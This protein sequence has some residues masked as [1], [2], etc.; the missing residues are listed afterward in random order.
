ML[1]LSESRNATCI[2]FA[3]TFFF[4]SIICLFLGLVGALSGGTFEING[5]SGMVLWLRSLQSSLLMETFD[6]DLPRDDV[7]L[8]FDLTSPPG[9]GIGVGQG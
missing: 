3:L 1:F 2:A 5:S 4:K 6:D 8:S 7:V 9:W